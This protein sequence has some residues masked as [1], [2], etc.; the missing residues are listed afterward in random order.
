MD[1]RANAFKAQAIDK[2]LLFESDQCLSIMAIEKYQTFGADI[3]LVG[4]KNPEYVDK[5]K[6]YF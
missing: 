4:M 5:L 6:D 2:G 3:I 1:Q